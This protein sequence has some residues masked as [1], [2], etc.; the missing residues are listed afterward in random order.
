MHTLTWRQSIQS[1]MHA[2]KIRIAHFLKDH[3]RY[4]IY[5]RGSFSGSLTDLIVFNFLSRSLYH[6]VH[7]GH[8][9]YSRWH[10]SC[11]AFS[12]SII[13]LDVSCEF[14]STW[15]TSLEHRQYLNLA[16]AWRPKILGFL[17]FLSAT[18]LFEQEIWTSTWVCKSKYKIK[19]NSFLVTWCE[20]NNIDI[21]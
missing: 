1:K 8:T 17:T 14:L 12:C 13:P 5:T 10:P 20:L 18:F 9:L 4:E 19:R 11:P 7:R 21:D 2:N 6:I 15:S 16:F 3:V